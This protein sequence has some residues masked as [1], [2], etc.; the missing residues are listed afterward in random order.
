MLAVS[1]MLL[2]DTSGGTV[3]DASYFIANNLAPIGRSILAGW[4]TCIGA[5]TIGLFPAV[6]LSRSSLTDFEGLG[7]AVTILLPLAVLPLLVGSASFAFLYAGIG[8]W[9][10]YLFGEAGRGASAVLGSSI[11]AHAVRYAPI[12]LWLAVLAAGDVSGERRRYARQLNASGRHWASIELFGLWTPTVLVVLAFAYQDAAN[13]F[14]IT[15][16]ALS[17]S[18]ATKSELV[19]HALSREFNLLMTARPAAQAMGA[20]VLSSLAVSL[21]LALG[22]LLVALATAI[23]LKRIAKLPAQRLQSKNPSNQA[24]SSRIAMIPSFIVVLGLTYSLARIGIAPSA[25]LLRDLMPGALAAATAAGLSWGLA[26]YCAYRLRDQPLEYDHRIGRYFAVAGSLAI[27]IGFVPP[28][29]LA[30]AVFGI[31]YALDP[32][33]SGTGW[34]WLVIAETARFTPIVFVLLVPAAFAVSARRVDHLRA[35][36]AGFVDRAMI[37]FLRPAAAVHVAIVIIAFNLIL[38]ESVVAAVFQADI[39]WVADVMRRA[40][41]GRSAQY[42]VAGLLIVVQGLIFGALLLLWGHSTLLRWRGRRDAH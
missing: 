5:L 28:L 9:W 41:V 1:G 37:A 3:A 22:F 33:A 35:I 31:A 12:L 8:K 29:G 14:L 6:F 2:V 13:D 21:I 18:E 38:N 15:Q 30:A 34:T 39:P 4:L 24:S 7:A 36:G 23:A 10:I 26:A 16:L 25:G 32:G 17:P 19:G 40:T 11:L 20:I 27:T 42:G